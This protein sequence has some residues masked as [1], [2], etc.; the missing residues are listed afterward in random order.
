[1]NRHMKTQHGQGFQLLQPGEGLT[2]AEDHTYKHVQKA[3]RKGKF[4]LHHT[5]DDDL[6]HTERNQKQDAQNRL[7]LLGLASATQRKAAEAARAVIGKAKAWQS[8]STTNTNPLVYERE[9][10]DNIT[11][12]E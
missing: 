5:K 6:N 11:D 9:G 1:M 12:N 8:Q 4:I 3:L 7:S 10:S 2:H